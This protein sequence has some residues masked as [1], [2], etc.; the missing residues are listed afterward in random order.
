MI[1]IIM[2]KMMNYRWPINFGDDNDWVE[3]D[4]SHGSERN[5]ND[6]CDER[7]QNENE[8]IYDDNDNDKIHNDNA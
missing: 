1:D 6:N 7:N 5:Q 8:R 3:N 2:V 4:K